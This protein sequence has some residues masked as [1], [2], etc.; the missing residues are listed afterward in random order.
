[1]VN[2][3]L[4]YRGGPVSFSSRIIWIIELMMKSD[5]VIK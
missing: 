5:I 1:M 3:S 4:E 2:H